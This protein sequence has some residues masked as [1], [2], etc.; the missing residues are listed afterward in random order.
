M[1]LSDDLRRPRRITLFFIFLSCLVLVVAS[2]SDSEI[3]LKVKNNLQNSNN[4]NALLS[5]WSTSTS[6]CSGDRANWE[7]VLCYQ[8]QVHGLKLENMGLKGVID[9][10]SLKE[11]PY[12]R[13]ISFMNNN[14]DGPWPEVNKITGLKSL[15]LSD[16]KFSGLIPDQA[17]EGM[18]WLKKIHLSNNQFEGHIP[19]S[20]ALLSRLLELR[21]EGNKFTGVLP[22]L[23]TS[24]LKSFSVANNLLRGEIPFHLRKMS[25][26]AFSGE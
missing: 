16:N 4:N 19:A 6:P 22:E 10:E 8:G 26:S 5:S 14:F 15:Y 13:S 24:E 25:A 21:L 20:V 2:S 1:A 3:L 7:G 9:V 23:Q 18:Q 12:L 17:F 11:L